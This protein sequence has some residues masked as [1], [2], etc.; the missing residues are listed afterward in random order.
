M[1]G[2]RPGFVCQ[3]LACAAALHG[4]ASGPAPIDHFYRI[5]VA[6]PSDSN[7]EPLAGTLHVDRLRAD[8]LARDRNVVY[9]LE[10]DTA[11]IRQ[12]AYPRWT[13]PPAISLQT[14]LISFLQQANAAEIVMAANARTR[15]SWIVDGRVIH[16][17]SL[18]GGP[19]PRVIVELDLHVMTADGDILMRRTY[20]ETRPA[21]TSGIAPVADALNEAVHS[22]FERF[23]SDLRAAS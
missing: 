1:K 2:S 19:H 6:A 3:I 4:C 11:E 20:L 22:I 12:Y 23:L 9:R 8:A 18:A 17:E 21:S 16:F 13:D 5:E 7:G 10:G 14:E 15:P